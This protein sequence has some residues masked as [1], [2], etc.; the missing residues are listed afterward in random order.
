[1]IQILRK[2]LLGFTRDRA[3]N[4]AVVSALVLPVVVGAFGI[5]AEATSWIASKRALQ[6]AADAAAIAAATNANSNYDIEAKAVAAQYGFKDG[7]NGVTVTASNT[8]TC[9]AGA[10]DPC[11]SVT[12][13]L[14]TPVLLAQVVGYRG[15]TTV[16]GAPSKIISATAIATQGTTPRPYCLLAL[17]TTQSGPAILTNGAPKGD[18]TG[19]N[20]MSNNGA[21]C[22]GHD[23]NADVGDAYGTNDGCGVVQHSNVKKVPDPYADL[24]KNIPPDPCQGKYGS[25]TYPQEPGKKGTWTPRPENIPTSAADWSSVTSNG[26]TT[27]CGDVQLPQGGLT[28]SQDT[29]LIIYNGQLDTNGATLS[30][31]AGLTVIFAGDNGSYTHAPTGGGTLDFAAPTADGP[32]KGMAI[33]QSPTASNGSTLNTGVDMS[34][35]GNSPTWDITGAVYMPNANVTL[36]GAVN[37]SNNGTSCF[38]MVVDNLLINGTGSI[39]AHGECSK[40]GVIPPTGQVPSRGQLV[41]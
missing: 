37:K 9:P 5:G 15:D 39:L 21:L 28:L 31:T 32:W 14:T 41:Q 40:A 1:M 13:S 26:V 18:L 27:I 7:S 20:I 2:T 36:S 25:N 8:A 19:C 34:A 17:G 11:Y 35:A 10:A 12:V 3:A 6:N 24:A 23:L 30:S 38:V 16:N 33:Y 29:T 22:N 4:V